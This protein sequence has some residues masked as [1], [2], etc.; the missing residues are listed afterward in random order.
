MRSIP[1]LQVVA[2][3]PGVAHAAR[4]NDDMEAG[5]LGD[6]LALLDRFGEP[7]L[8]R[9]QEPAH[10]D[11]GIDHKGKYQ[12]AVSTSDALLLLMGEIE[13]C[14]AGWCS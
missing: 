9:V 8:R 4:G 2:N 10:I 11:P 6:R 12:G 14:C 5:E 13:K 3:A 7:Q 1:V